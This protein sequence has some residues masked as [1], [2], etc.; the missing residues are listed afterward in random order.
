MLQLFELETFT[1]YCRCEAAGTQTYSLYFKR[2]PTKQMRC[3]VKF[4]GH[5]TKMPS[6]GL[7]SKYVSQKS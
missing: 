1:G 4:R 3:P 6:T 7:I 5:G 2:P